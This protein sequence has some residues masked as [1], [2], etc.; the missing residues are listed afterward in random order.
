MNVVAPILRPPPAAAQLQPLSPDDMRGQIALVALNL[1]TIK[2]ALALIEETR[3]ARGMPKQLSEEIGTALR[4]AHGARE[5]ADAW[6]N[7][8][9]GR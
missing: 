9:L 4:L 5:A 8:A 1:S 2:E 6:V 3:F 7:R